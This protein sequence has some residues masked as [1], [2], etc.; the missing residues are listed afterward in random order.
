MGAYGWVA[1]IASHGSDILWLVTVEAPGYPRLPSSMQHDAVVNRFY[2]QIMLVFYL[3]FLREDPR[4]V[5]TLAQLIKAYSRLNLKKAEQYPFPIL[6]RSS[7]PIT[8]Y[9][10]GK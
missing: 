5:K 8:L 9:F 1:E 7:Q 6:L 10:H 3:L 2:L 4:D